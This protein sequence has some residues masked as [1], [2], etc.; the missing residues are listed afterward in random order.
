MKVVQ[1]NSSFKL[2]LKNALGYARLYTEKILFS[3]AEFI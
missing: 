1:A 3:F 2:L